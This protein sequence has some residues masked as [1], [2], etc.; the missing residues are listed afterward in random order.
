MMHKAGGYCFVDFAC[1]APYVKIDMHP[2]LEDA[3]LDAIFFSPHKFLGGPGSSGV[4]IFN[5]DLYHRKVPDK[6]R[7][8]YS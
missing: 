5:R 3:D 7:G 6:S 2:D 1:S 8:R 4:I